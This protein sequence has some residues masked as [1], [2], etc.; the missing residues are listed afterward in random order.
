MVQRALRA[1][2]LVDLEDQLSNAIYGPNDIS[3]SGEF[4][5]QFFGGV[6]ARVSIV[7]DPEMTK[8]W[9]STQYHSWNSYV[10]FTMAH[11]ICRV[12]F[13]PRVFG[14]KCSVSTRMWKM[15]RIKADAEYAEKLKES[16]SGWWCCFNSSWSMIMMNFFTIPCW[17]LTACIHRYN[18]FVKL[19]IQSHQNLWNLRLTPYNTPQEFYTSYLETNDFKLERFHELG[20]KKGMSKELVS[21]TLAKKKASWILDPSLTFFPGASSKEMLHVPLVG[22]LK[23]R[24]YI[25]IYEWLKNTHDHVFDSF[26]GRGNYS[27]KCI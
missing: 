8:I 17:F 26:L 1:Q 20:K 22:G 25:Y 16:G 11:W 24:T 9:S 19:G 2:R 23:K 12:F 3:R 18:I 6:N 21:Q 10:H 13:F 4:V 14:S 7:R 15:P 27:K 5:F